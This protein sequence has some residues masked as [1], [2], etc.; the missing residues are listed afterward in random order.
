MNQQ[1]EME[2]R[3]WA[4]LDGA[5][6]D[7]ERSE[8]ARL[9]Q[10]QAA[11]KALYGEL[12]EV[13]RSIGAL[14]LD[15]PSMRFTRNVM[16][17]IAQLQI[18]PATKNYINKRIIWGIALFFITMLVG[19]FIYGLGQINWSAAGS[20]QATLGIDLNKVDYGPLFN[21]NLLYAFLLINIVAGLFL[22]DRY[23]ARKRNE[24]RNAPPMA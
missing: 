7:E 6:S 17:S 13:H 11:W 15:E 22:L 10:E 19:F 5:G 2:L 9:V 16:E 3:I 21:N 14:E 12:L 4:Y 23:L 1:E 8:V 20:E 18:A 24:Y